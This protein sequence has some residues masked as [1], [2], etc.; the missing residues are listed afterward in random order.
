MRRR[1]TRTITFQPAADVAQ[2]LGKMQELQPR[3][4]RSRIINQAVRV[5]LKPF[6][7]K[8]VPLQENPRTAERLGP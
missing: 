3:S 6:A 8:R 2:L 4:N 5:F 7:G 1:Q